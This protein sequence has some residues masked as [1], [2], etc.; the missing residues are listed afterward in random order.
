MLTD[1]VKKKIKEK[2]T[3]YYYEADGTKSSYCA[4]QQEDI[5]ALMALYTEMVEGELEQ[6]A[7][8]YDDNKSEWYGQDYALPSVKQYL[9]EKK[10]NL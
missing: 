5:D 9:L 10:G 3:R 6:F 4:L 7:K 2:T 1:E 8:W